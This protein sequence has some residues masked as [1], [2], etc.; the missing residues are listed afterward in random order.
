MKK[1]TYL[2]AFLVVVGGMACKTKKT[3][4]PKAK[5]LAETKLE[6][7]ITVMGITKGD[8]ND[9][10]LALWGTP[11]KTTKDDKTVYSFVSVYHDDAN[12]NRMFS[13]TYDKKANTVNHIR[14]TGSKQD[15]YNPTKEYFKSKNIAD[16]KVNFLGMHKDEILK[17]FGTPDRVN[18]GNYEF[19]KGPISVT[20]IC[21]D[22]NQG[23][24]SEI[25]IYWNMYWKE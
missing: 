14:L 15:N 24:C 25:Y 4:A 9:K 21:Y 16:T 17:I 6:D 13:Y 12:G 3:N 22:F 1:L 20:F 5:P 10:A 23:K 11:T 8:L 7:F 2:A 18:A 19:V